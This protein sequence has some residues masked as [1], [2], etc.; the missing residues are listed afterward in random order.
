MFTGRSHPGM[1]SYQF[2]RSHGLTISAGKPLPLQLVASARIHLDG[3]SREPAYWG[4]ANVDLMKRYR[5]RMMVLVAFGMTPP[6]GVLRARTDGTVVP[7]LEVTDD[8]RAYYKETKGIIDSIFERNGCQL[9]KADF[10]NGEGQPHGDLHFSTAHQVG[11]CRM[12][13]VSTGGVVDS[14]GEVFGCPGLFVSDGAAIPSSLSVNTSLTILAN[15]ER[16]AD[17][18]VRRFRPVRPRVAVVG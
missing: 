13:N 18:M 16:I 5:R 7:D 15:A 3:D 6:V 8:L 11:S 4:Q 9:I 10:I 2:L 14:T 1:I 12:A 17:G